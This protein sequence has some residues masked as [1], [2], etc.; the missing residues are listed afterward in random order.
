[1]EEAD[2]AFGMLVPGA[3]RTEAVMGDIVNLMASG[4]T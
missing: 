1:M 3:V 4:T 2:E